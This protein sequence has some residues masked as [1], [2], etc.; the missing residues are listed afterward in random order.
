ML[1]TGASVSTPENTRQTY[2]RKLLASSL[3]LVL[4]VAGRSAGRKGVS[5]SYPPMR[6]VD[7]LRRGGG[8]I[9]TSF[10]PKKPNPPDIASA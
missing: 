8:V 6:R 3:S 1:R 4:V 10:P 7:R 5:R 2:F 9:S